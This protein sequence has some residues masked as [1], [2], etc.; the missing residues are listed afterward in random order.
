MT[1]QL[2]RNI[3][4]Y[5]RKTQIA[6]VCKIVR[7]TLEENTVENITQFIIV[8]KLPCLRYLIFFMVSHNYQITYVHK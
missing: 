5:Y 7:K 1:F 2:T 3:T 6:D 8:E 4:L